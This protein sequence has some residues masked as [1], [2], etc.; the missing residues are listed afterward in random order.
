MR[1]ARAAV[2][3][4]AVLPSEVLDTAK[5]VVHRVTHGGQRVLSWHRTR[6]STDPRYPVALAAGGGALIQV[7]VPNLAVGNALRT[8]LHTV[9]GTSTP[10]LYG[11]RY[12]VDVDRWQD[13]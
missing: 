10:G 8:V 6:M 9:L 5:H 4:A 2:K 1:W 11:G 12:G 7:L 13:D 3:A